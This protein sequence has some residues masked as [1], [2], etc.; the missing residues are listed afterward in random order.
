M[1][2]RREVYAMPIASNSLR[3]LSGGDEEPTFD[4]TT[5][6]EISELA[7]DRWIV[8]RGNRRPSYREFR[9]EHLRD[10]LKPATLET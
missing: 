7:R 5:V 6:D 2:S 8:P 9:R 4:Y 3:F 10:A 1:A